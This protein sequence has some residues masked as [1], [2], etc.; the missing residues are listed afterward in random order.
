MKPRLC[1]LA[2]LQQDKTDGTA[3]L[4]ADKPKP[5]R[6]QSCLCASCNQLCHPFRAVDQKKIAAIFQRMGCHPEQRIR[7]APA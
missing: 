4:M 3:L 5:F 2:K 6:F 7:V 1:T